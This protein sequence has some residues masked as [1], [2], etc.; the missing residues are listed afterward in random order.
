MVFR[1]AVHASIPVGAG[2]QHAA[3]FRPA[4]DAP[5]GGRGPGSAER[6]ALSGAGRGGGALRGPPPLAATRR[7][8]NEHVLQ[9]PREAAL[10][11][12]PGAALRGPP[13]TGGSPRPPPWPRAAGPL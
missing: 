4:R 13:S 11:G 10:R 9:G 5:C 2:F 3:R 8:A 1:I 12:S 7:Y 6:R